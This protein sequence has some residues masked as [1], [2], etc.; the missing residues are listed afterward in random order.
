MAG[1][2][3]NKPGTAVEA[4]AAEFAGKIGAPAHCVGS[5]CTELPL[6]EYCKNSIVGGVRPLVVTVTLPALETAV[7]LIE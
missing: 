5:T 4:G 2:K 7:P 1:A 6:G 3:L